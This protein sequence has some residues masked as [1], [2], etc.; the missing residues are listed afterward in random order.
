MKKEETKKV[1]KTINKSTNSTKKKSVKDESVQM[2]QESKKAKIELQL[3][4]R[5]R[6]VE[7]W[8]AMY[9]ADKRKWNAPM[10]DGINPMLNKTPLATEIDNF[11]VV[12]IDTSVPFEGWNGKPVG[13]FSMVVTKNGDRVKPIGKQFVVDPQYQGKGVGKAMLLAL[14]KELKK[15]GHTWYYIGCSS[16][17]KRLLESLGAKPYG[18]DDQHDLYRFNVQL[19]RS[20]FDKQYEEYVLNRVDI[21]NGN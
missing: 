15:V 13:I 1:K 5:E 11:C 16:M 6:Y 19:D 21:I 18:E 8:K 7:A 4:K 2:K 17:S 10:F 9:F 3:C 20:D 12:A 14:E